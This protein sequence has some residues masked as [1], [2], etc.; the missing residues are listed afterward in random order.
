VEFFIK[1][2]LDKQALGAA[3]KEIR[4][5]TERIRGVLRHLEALV[6]LLLLRLSELLKQ[7]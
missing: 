1:E 6:T 4:D 3:V 2:V 5:T 7:L